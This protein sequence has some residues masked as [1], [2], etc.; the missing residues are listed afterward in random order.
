MLSLSQRPLGASDADHELFVNREEELARARRSLNLGLNLYVAGPPGIGRTSFLHQIQRDHSEARFI[1]LREF[2]SLEDKLL[3][4]ERAVQDRGVLYRSYTESVMPR[5]GYPFRTKRVRVA[6]DPLVDLKKATNQLEVD[7]ARLLLLVD[8]LDSDGRRHLFGRF[9]DELWELPIQWVVS[10]TDLCL[11][12]PADAF[13]ESVIELGELGQEV[14]GEMLYRRALPGSTEEQ[15]ALRDIAD[16]VTATLAPC[17]PRRALSVAR[18]IFL[19]DDAMGASN[20]L[21]EIQ[22]LRSHLSESASRVLDGLM[23]HGPTHAGDEQL[24]AEIGVTRSRVVQLLA[25]LESAG[26]AT[27]QRVGRRKLYSAFPKPGI[28]EE[29]GAGSSGDSQEHP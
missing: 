11:E 7:E 18:D 19:S 16:S 24:L 12:P 5:I 25:E 8:D 2:E 23:V 17:T 27:A 26:L 21:E 6:G 14:L 28:P 10:G 9:R 1:R 20:R 13:F 29:V 4:I 22:E 15:A 3:E